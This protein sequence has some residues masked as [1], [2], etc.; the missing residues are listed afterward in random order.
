MTLA[1]IQARLT[2]TRLPG[3][4]MKPILGQPMILRQIE[5]ARR[6]RVLTDLVVATSVDPSD[7]PLAAALADAGVAVHRGPLDDV[8][9]RYVGALD[10]H[11]SETVVR[12]TADCPL[13]DPEVLDAT[14]E[15]MR[16]EGADYAHCRTQSEGFPKGLDVE[17]MTAATLRRAAAEA[18][19]R[20]EQEHVTW[21]VW[22][23]P[24]RYKVVRLKPPYEQ[25]QVRW[26]VDRADDFEFVTAVYEALYPSRP[27]F[28]SDDIRAFVKSR[29]DLIQYGGEPRA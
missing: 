1:I 25:G 14:V 11:P 29:P 2:S 24:D 3:K 9:G 23:R 16:S 17:A 21:G 12:L 28:T 15:L 26:T 22:G 6:S 4:V 27:T 13:L 10:A 18:S 20:E 19:T 7:D 5:R 8:L